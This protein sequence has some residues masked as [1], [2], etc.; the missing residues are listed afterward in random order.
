MSK[1]LDERMVLVLSIIVDNYIKY[2]QSD[3][4]RVLTKRYQIEF[5]PATMR[6]V[7]LDLEDA[8]YLTHTHTSGGKIPTEKGY[9]F[10]LEMIMSNFSPNLKKDFENIVVNKGLGSLDEKMNKIL[11]VASS[12]SGL[13]SLVTM[14]DFSRTKIKNIEFIKISEDK[15]ICVVV[16]DTNMIDTR[17]VNLNKDITEKELKEF[18]RYITENYKGWT[19]TDINNSIES[20]IKNHKQECES[21]IKTLA[22]Q[23]DKTKLLVS[24]VKN[25]FNYSSFNDDLNKLRK[26][27]SVLEEKRAIVDILKGVMESDRKILIGND[28]PIDEL[29]DLGLVSSSYQYKNQNVGVVG[30]MGPMNMNYK[31]MLNIVESAKKKIGDILNN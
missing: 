6:N 22:N 20:Y 2:K 8:G 31:E 16:S 13:V 1:R 18:S 4:S 28:F 27:V 26:I 9:K 15:I 29:K 24:G 12:L 14:P 30:I 17:I 21:I 11:N 10:Y 19:L 23:T 7:M 25:I 3:G 5:S